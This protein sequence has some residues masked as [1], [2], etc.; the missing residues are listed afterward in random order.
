MMCRRIGS[1][2]YFTGQTNFFHI[3]LLLEG[4]IAPPPSRSMLALSVKTALLF[5]LVP[6]TT[7][8]LTAIT[9]GTRKFSHVFM[10]RCTSVATSIFL[11]ANPRIRTTSI[12]LS[13]QRNVQNVVKLKRQHFARE[14]LN[15]GGSLPRRHQT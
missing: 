1:P 15:I 4:T 5:I 13:R 6:C 7:N 2:P 8:V 11:S 12:L 9:L 3:I 10:H 14:K